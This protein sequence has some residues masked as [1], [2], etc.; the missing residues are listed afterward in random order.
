ML[1][2]CWW[3]KGG[4]KRDGREDGTVVTA[5]SLFYCTPDPSSGAQV[6]QSLHGFSDIN[7]LGSF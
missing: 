3:G 2:R 6:R 7:K 5:R 4:A 1:R